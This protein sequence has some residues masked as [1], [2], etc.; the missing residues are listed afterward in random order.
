MERIVGFFNSNLSEGVKGPCHMIF[1]WCKLQTYLVSHFCLKVSALKLQLRWLNRTSLSYNTFIL[2]LL[3]LIPIPSGAESTALYKAK[4][5][6][7][8]NICANH[9]NNIL[10]I[11]A[12]HPNILNICANSPKSGISVLF[13]RIMRLDKIQL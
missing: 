11:C 9:P 10:N 2:L 12:N 1:T 3:I 6:N 8:L 7:I 4:H 5:P 13:E